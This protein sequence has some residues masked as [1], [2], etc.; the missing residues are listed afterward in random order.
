[1]PE[2]LWTEVH[3]FQE[4]GGSDQDHPPKKKYVKA[5]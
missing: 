3:D 4:A 2:E 5:I 1:M